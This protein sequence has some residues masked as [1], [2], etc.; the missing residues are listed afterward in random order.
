MQKL[1]LL[2]LLAPDIHN[3]LMWQKLGKQDLNSYRKSADRNVLALFHIADSTLND[4]GR[5]ELAVVIADGVILDRV[6]EE[7]CLY[8]TGADCHNADTAIFKLDV[9]CTREAEHKCL[10]GA[11]QTDIGHGLEC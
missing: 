9:K 8:P 6:I 3:K 11:V 5:L 10:C 4:L 7:F 1:Y 2:L